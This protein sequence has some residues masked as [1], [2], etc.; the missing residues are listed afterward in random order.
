MLGG[1][2]GPTHIVTVEGPPYPNADPCQRCGSTAWIEVLTLDTTCG[3]HFEGM[4][5]DGLAAHEC[6]T[7]ELECPAC[8]EGIA[9]VN[10]AETLIA[11]GGAPAVA[12]AEQVAGARGMI[13]A[14]AFIGGGL[15][16]LAL[17][18]YA[19][20]EAGRLDR[21]EQE[22]ADTCLHDDRA[23]TGRIALE[24]VA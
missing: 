15:V 11:L 22:E 4:D 12:G 7:V 10:E 24:A 6:V 13:E 16:L 2:F 20:W 19:L 14:L 5:I 21:D 18:L 3:L 17:S 8:V 1:G 9:A 23:R